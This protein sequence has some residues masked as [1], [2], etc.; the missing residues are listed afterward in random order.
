MNV[1]FTRLQNE[2]L[3]AESVRKPRPRLPEIEEIRKRR[4]PADERPVLRI[5][6]EEYPPEGYPEEPVPTPG[7]GIQRG[8]VVVDFVL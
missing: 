2:T 6:I 5:D 1:H 8:V 4:V 7:D 3:R